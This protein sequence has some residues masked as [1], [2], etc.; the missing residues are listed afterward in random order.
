LRFGKLS[1]CMVLQIMEAQAS[2]EALYILEVGLA[3]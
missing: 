3:L 1:D 2:Q